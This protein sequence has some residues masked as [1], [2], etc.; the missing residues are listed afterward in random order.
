MDHCDLSPRTRP[1]INCRRPRIV[2]SPF[3]SSF[4]FSL[5]PLPSLAHLVF[6]I[7]TSLLPVS[8]LFSTHPYLLHYCLPPLSFFSLLFSSL[9]VNAPA[10]FN[11]GYASRSALILLWNLQL[12]PLETHIFLR[13]GFGT[14]TD[15][16]FDACW[17]FI[18][19]ENLSQICLCT[20]GAPLERFS[21]SISSNASPSI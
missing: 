2:N 13:P 8:L 19:R 20:F 4:S 6:V 15:N 17:C 7:L 21:R 18:N 10:L 11:V 12:V 5:S 16:F 1:S 14:L 9:L 3:H